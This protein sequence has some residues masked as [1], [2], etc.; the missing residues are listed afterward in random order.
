MQIN[1]QKNPSLFSSSLSLMTPTTSL[2]SKNS[3]SKQ[4][5]H[6]DRSLI[7]EVKEAKNLFNQLL[8]QNT[9]SNSNTNASSNNI[10]STLS[11]SYTPVYKQTS[12]P[13]P[14]TKKSS[15]QSTIQTLKYDL[16]NSKDYGSTHFYCL[17]VLN[18]DAYVASTNF[19]ASKSNTRD[20]QQY[21]WD[22]RFVF[23]SLPLDVKNLKVI[24][25]ANKHGAVSNTLYNQNIGY[26]MLPKS[27]SKTSFKNNHQSKP[28][29]K[30]H[31]YRS[32]AKDSVLVGEFSIALGNIINKGERSKFFPSIS[33]EAFE[34]NFFFFIKVYPTNGTNWT[35]FTTVACKIRIQVR[36]QRGRYV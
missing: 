11:S 33:I 26:R 13:L 31:L 19:T 7:V 36:R 6:V 23:N 5:F 35:M 16:F 21:F 17:V 34:K 18:D 20:S 2:A 25:Y 28:D 1:N 15:D 3:L 9:P 29:S 27:A 12:S 24:A 14:Q 8:N 22:E 30:C 4:L 10:D 32:K